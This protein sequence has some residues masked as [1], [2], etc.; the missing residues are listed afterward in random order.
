[1]EIT[2]FHP[3]IEYYLESLEKKTKD[4]VSRTIHLLSRMGYRLSMPFSKKIEKNLYELR[5]LTPENIRVFYTF[6]Q[7]KI[8]LLHAIHKKTQKLIL[9]DLNTARNRLKLLLS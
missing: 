5:I 4:K 3:D 2:Y 6:Y 9:K 7:D 1:M 8:V